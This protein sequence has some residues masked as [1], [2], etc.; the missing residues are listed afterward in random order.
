M[1]HTSREL[2]LCELELVKAVLS[3]CKKHHLTVFMMGG[4]FLGAVR[5]KGFI[6]WDDDVDLGMSRNDYETFLKPLPP[7][8]CP[9]ATCSGILPRPGYALL[10]GAG[11]RSQ[12]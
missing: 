4:T 3:I 7:M 1:D 9:R 6:P 10:S 12:L 2:Q 8:S 5:H 11:S